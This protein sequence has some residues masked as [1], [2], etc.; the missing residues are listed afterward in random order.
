MHT[1]T[2]DELLSVVQAYHT[3]VS[4]LLLLYPTP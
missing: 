3:C 2:G 4:T 1:L